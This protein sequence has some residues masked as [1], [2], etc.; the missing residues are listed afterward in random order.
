MTTLVDE[1]FRALRAL[2]HTGSTT[3]M[4]RTWLISEGGDAS[5]PQ[6]N[7]LWVSMLESKGFG[8]QYNDAWY[9]YLGSLGYT[10]AIN[11]RETQFWENK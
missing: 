10:G 3:D 9:A 2:G 4:L 5:K 11:E 7:D 6:M 1:R 8:E